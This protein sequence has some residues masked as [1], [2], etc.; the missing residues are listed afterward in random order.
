MVVH[1]PCPGEPAPSLLSP[2]LRCLPVTAGTTSNPVFIVSAKLVFIMFSLCSSFIHCF[3]NMTTFRDVLPN[4][5]LVTATPRDEGV[6]RPM[7]EKAKVKIVLCPRDPLVF[8]QPPFNLD[9]H[10]LLKG[11]LDSRQVKLNNARQLFIFARAEIHLVLG[12]FQE[13]LGVAI[14][15][16]VVDLS[17]LNR[18][19]FR[20]CL[21]ATFILSCSNFLIRLF[22]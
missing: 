10:K 16:D 11:H 19:L 3:P 8:L 13:A 15:Q 9:L 5:H 17:S 12:A 4:V 7:L 2:L 1:M 20:Y 22:L 6:L 18:E 21:L 14:T